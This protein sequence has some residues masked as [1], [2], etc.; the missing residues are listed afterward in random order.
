MLSYNLKEA[1]ITEGATKNT[2]KVGASLEGSNFAGMDG[3]MP[4]L[5]VSFKLIGDEFYDGAAAITG[6]TFSYMQAGQE[7]PVSIPYFFV[8]KTFKL[9]STHS[10]ITGNIK[11]Q[12]FLKENGAINT[13]IDFS[14]IGAKIYA[15]AAD[16]KVHK[17]TISA[18]GS[19]NIMGVPASGEAYTLYVKVPGHLTSAITANLGKQIG[20]EWYGQSYNFSFSTVYAGDVNKD[21]VIDIRDVQLIAEAYGTSSETI[22]QEDINRDGTVY[23]ADIR[24]VEKNFLRVGPDAKSTKQP[25]ET[26]N[27]KGLAAFLHELGLEPKN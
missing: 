12:G 25:K 15:K 10:K 22:V 4:F 9:I 1:A 26:I 5:D 20:G 3:D 6:V 19:Y 23:E 16:G 14:A 18:N 7:K 17:G 27:N 24:F 21:K 8:G 13:K 11:P 2:V